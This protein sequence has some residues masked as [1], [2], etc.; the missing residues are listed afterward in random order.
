MLKCFT[1]LLLMTRK[2]GLCL[3]FLPLRPVPA[4]T[5]RVVR[6]ESLD[7][8]MSIGKIILSGSR[9]GNIKETA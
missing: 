6:A 1:D 5:G 3:V 9:E 4:R 8:L 2:S 7:V